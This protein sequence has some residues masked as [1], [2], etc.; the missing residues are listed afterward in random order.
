QLEGKRLAVGSTGSGTR[1]LAL[2]LL[3]ANGIQPGGA[4]QFV[5]LDADNAA[6]ALV[7]GSVDGVF[8]MSDVASS[9]LMR[10]LLQTPGIQI[11]DFKQADAYT[12]RITYLNRLVLPEGSIDF[13]KNIP[14]QNIHLIGPTVELIARADLHP[15][16]SDLL[17]EAAR[18]VHGRAGLLKRQGEFPAPL[19]HEFPISAEAKRYYKSGKSFLYRYLPFWPANLMNRLLLILVP[20]LVVLIPVLRIIPALF[21]WHVKLRIFRWYR[22][23]LILEKDVSLPLTLMKREELLERLDQIEEGVNKMKVPAFFA[24]Q[25]YVL[26][27]HI[28]FVHRRLMEDRHVH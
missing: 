7:E 24:D 26:R 20:M 25:F 10:T 1:A 6:K 18:E 14:F 22:S 23:L 3:A 2:T 27:E 16:L 12:R 11:F 15:A 4:T 8:L 21:R 13:G 9:Q 5:D 17:L 19:E 28:R